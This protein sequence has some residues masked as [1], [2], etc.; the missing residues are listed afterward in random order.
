[1]SKQGSTL[2][3]LELR[4][5][6]AP[7]SRKFFESIPV[8]EGLASREVI[9]Q[10]RS[11][12]LSSMGRANYERHIS[13]L[14]EFSSF[15][16]AALV[17]SQDGYLTSKYSK[18]EGERAREF[19]VNE[20]PAAKVTAFLECF[21]T[22]VEVS[23]FDDRAQ[24]SVRFEAYLAL[25]GRYELTKVA[26]WKLVRQALEEGKI[27][28]SDNLLN[29]L[30]GDC[31]QAAIAEGV[32][33]LKR[34]PFPRQLLDVKSGV[35]EFVPAPRPRSS[36][37]YDYVEELL[38]HPASDGRHRF[39]WLVLAP[40]LVNVRNL[41]NDEAIEKIR[42]FVAVAGETGDLRRFIEYNVRRAKRNGLLPPTLSTLR[43][44]H[45]DLYWLLPKEALVAEGA[46]AQGQKS[47]R[48]T[49]S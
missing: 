4:Y 37:R 9:E 16:S 5:P 15:F 21:G 20:K 41:E 23:Y 27:L 29:D 36:R 43:S 44:E 1:L 19:F 12:L 28:L 14:I 17:A 38:K 31:A 40:Y 2:T 47:T 7:S 10:T 3:D 13:E 45:P 33:N 8:E 32:R 22:D 25:V 42:G 49:A 39:V 48:Q 24:Y 46:S 11:R 26:K 34:A 18:K 35:M 6:F 30:F